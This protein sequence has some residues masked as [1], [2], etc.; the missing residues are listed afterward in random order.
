M[1]PQG[2]DHLGP[3]THQQIARSMLHQL[4]L[5]FGRLR[6]D[7]PH[8]W[9][10]HRLT[11]RFGVSRVVLVA[12]DVG[13]HVLRRHQPHPVT[14]LRQFTRPVMGRGARLYADQARRQRF[15]ER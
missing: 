15:E 9:A 1:R 6:R 7:E 4:A 11:D 8:G 2:V 5:L 13:L 12:L 10:P 3:L 14:K